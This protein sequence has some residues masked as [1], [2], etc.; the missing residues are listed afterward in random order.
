MERT[1]LSRRPCGIARS[2]DQIGDAW[3]LLVIRDVFLG[4]RRFAE[5]Q[6]SL[7]IAPNILSR[8]LEGLVRHGILEAR[9]YSTRPL[10]KE[11]VLTEKGAGLLPVLLA[12]ASWGNRWL[13][14]QGAPLIIVDPATRARLEPVVV[15][16]RSGKRLLPGEVAVLPGPGASAELRQR[17]RKPRVFSN[18]VNP[19]RSA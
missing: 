2:L 1:S 15:D 12:V 7:K 16:R 19:G 17:L 14:P 8:R 11:Y 18:V 13:A 3:S 10:R 6:E 4:T 5:L 9:S